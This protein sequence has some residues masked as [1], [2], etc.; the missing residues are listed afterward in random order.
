M[1][2]IQLEYSFLFLF[3]WKLFVVIGNAYPVIDFDNEEIPNNI[4]KK[5]VSTHNA[6]VPAPTY[7]CVHIP[8]NLNPCKF[9]SYDKIKENRNLRHIWAEKETQE[10]SE[11]NTNNKSNKIFYAHASPMNLK[12][13][14]KHINTI[15]YEI[16][17]CV[18][19]RLPFILPRCTDE[20]LANE[21]SEI[22]QLYPFKPDEDFSKAAYQFPMY[23]FPHNLE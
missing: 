6:V 8:S 17:R 21:K 7:T 9:G 18:P 22:Q 16:L 12:E 10:L 5:N 3:I 23:N 15:I 4:I 1:R 13:T 14:D 11:S 2:N 20:D 19:A